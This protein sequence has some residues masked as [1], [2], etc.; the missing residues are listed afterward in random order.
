[1]TSKLIEALNKCETQKSY[2]NVRYTLIDDEL[3]AYLEES[4]KLLEQLEK[5]NKLLDETMEADDKIIQQ[6][7]KENQDLKGLVDSLNK[8]QIIGVEM[9]TDLW[10]ENENRKKA[11]KILKEYLNIEVD[12]DSRTI[13]TDVGDTSIVGAKKDDVEDLLL[14]KEVL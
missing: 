10:N 2:E 8:E 13:I 3:R 11:L 5:D 7:I 6:L 1:M 9:Y 4:L 12:I 14:L